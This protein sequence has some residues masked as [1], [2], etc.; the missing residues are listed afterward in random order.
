MSFGPVEAALT[1]LD[2]RSPENGKYERCAAFAPGLF[3]VQ[4]CPLR[5]PAYNRTTCKRTGGCKKSVWQQPAVVRAVSG[6]NLVGPEAD[7]VRHDAEVHA[8][9]APVADVFYF[10]RAGFWRWSRV[11]PRAIGGSIGDQIDPGAGPLRDSWGNV[12]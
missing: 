12:A 4:R 11:S 7:I 6:N 2:P 8:C 9:G 10:V 3:A 1:S 5:L